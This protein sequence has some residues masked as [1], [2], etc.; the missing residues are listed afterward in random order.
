MIV[1][2]ASALLEVLLLSGPGRRALARME[3][4]HA[5]VHAPHLVDLEVAHVLRRYVALREMDG[6]EAERCL[7]QFRDLPIE[8]H[9]HTAM[10]GRVWE[11][12][13][14]LTAYDAAY[15][16]L[17]EALDCPLLTSDAR[18]AR[19]TG[20]SAQVELLA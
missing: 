19:S 12:R 10:L 14:N 6:A 15:V 4:P 18:L 5:S 9:A 2:D 13:A 8:R 16:T 7:R 11:L 1:V 3:Q 20:H 17:A